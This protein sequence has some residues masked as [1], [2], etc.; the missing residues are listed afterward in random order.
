MEF[1]LPEVFQRNTQ[2]RFQLPSRTLIND[3]QLFNGCLLVNQ[4]T[5]RDPIEYS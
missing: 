2:T 3:N 5:Y 4:E 1:R